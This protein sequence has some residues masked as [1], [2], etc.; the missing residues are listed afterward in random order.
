MTAVCLACL[1]AV[2][3]SAPAALAAKPKGLTL[4]SFK[5]KGSHGYRIDV[6]AAQGGGGKALALLMAGFQNLSA[7][8]E[9]PAEAGPGV[10]ADFGALGDLDLSFHR[11]RRQ[12]EQLSRSCK[13]VTENGVFRGDLTFSG[14]GGY[15]SA[16]AKAVSGEVSRFPNGL[17]FLESFRRA[18]GSSTPPFLQATSLVARSR[19]A[20]GSIELEASEMKVGRDAF[21]SAK[22]K[23]KTGEVKIV[24]SAA[25][26]LTKEALVFG[27]GKPP[28][29]A[30]LKLPP[31]ITGSAHFEDPVGGPPTWTGT[32][33][34]SLPGA[35][36]LAFAGPDF[37]AKTCLNASL[38]SGCKVDLPP[39]KGR[40]EPEL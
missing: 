30:D 40:P 20:N 7:T 17:C 31:P 25:V 10:H 33:A 5:L 19:T 9:A 12:V 4:S 18:S 15:T 35:P 8:Y 11:K 26:A 39:G 13:V 3:L 37:V 22:V 29:T 28:R 34:I 2:A 23:E 24:R 27:P 6:I 36:E 38:L 16:E 21:L 1:A 14:E 32:L